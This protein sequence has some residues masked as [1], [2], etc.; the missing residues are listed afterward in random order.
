MVLVLVGDSEYI[1]VVSIHYA[2]QQVFDNVSIIMFQVAIHALCGLTIKSQ[3]HFLRLIGRNDDLSDFIIQLQNSSEF[4]NDSVVLAGVQSNSFEQLWE[5]LKKRQGL[6]YRVAM[7][8][9]VKLLEHSNEVVSL[10]EGKN[11]LSPT[12]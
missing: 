5:V 8:S 3:E 9:L 12:S 6:F 1:L 7:N 2:F 10:F 4:M 11:N